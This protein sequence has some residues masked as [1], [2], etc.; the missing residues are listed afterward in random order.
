MIAGAMVGWRN[1]ARYLAP[2]ALA[3]VVAA[4]LRDRPQGD[5]GQA[6]HLA[7]LSIVQS[8]STTPTATHK[9]STKAKFY[10]VQPGDTL[11]R[12]SARTGVSVATLEQL[13]PNVNPNA[14]HPHAA[15]PAAAMR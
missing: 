13:N 12:I 9:V 2:L 11:S 14:L 4:T 1:P 3:A 10:V 8:S 15:A 6:L 5:P 7:S